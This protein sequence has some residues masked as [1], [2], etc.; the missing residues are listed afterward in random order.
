MNPL[1]KRDLN[2]E[3]LFLPGKYDRLNLAALRASLEGMYLSKENYIRVRMVSL[4]AI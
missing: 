3:V 2:K 4:D 1:C